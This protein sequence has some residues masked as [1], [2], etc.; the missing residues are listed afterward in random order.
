MLHNAWRAFFL[1]VVC[2]AVGCSDDD[3]Y[4]KIVPGMTQQEVEEI[5]GKP[6]IQ[7]EGVTFL[8]SSRIAMVMRGSDVPVINWSQE[9]ARIVWIYEP[10]RSETSGVVTRAEKGK[11]PHRVVFASISRFGIVF[12]PERGK[13]IHTGYYPVSVQR[14]R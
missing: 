5:L 13:V 3:G 14:I 12:D 8:D 2:A 4:A 1:A 7:R 10:T 6:E 9:D 11:P